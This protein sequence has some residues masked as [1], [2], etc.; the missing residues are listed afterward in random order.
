MAC[1]EPGSVY[2]TI[3]KDLVAFFLI[4]TTMKAWGQ[5]HNWL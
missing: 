2:V 3:F 1:G 5:Q 4:L